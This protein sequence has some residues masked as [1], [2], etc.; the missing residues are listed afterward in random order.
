MS[1]GKATTC[2]EDANSTDC[3]LQL[4]LQTLEDQIATDNAKFD[5]DPL[6]F[7]FTVPIALI[8]ALFALVTIFQAILAAGPGRRKSRYRA[9][10]RWADQ[11][12]MEWSWPDMTWMSIATTPLLRHGDLSAFL[13]EGTRTL[14][15][16]MN[17]Q[18]TNR[19]RTDTKATGK[20]RR[21]GVGGATWLD[22]L[23]VV[24]LG[25]F[26][27]HEKGENVKHL[28]TTADYL[29]G[30]LL[31]VPAYLDV[32]LI[33]AL[34]ATAGAQ[35]IR[36][37]GTD[38]M[39]YPVILGDNFQFDFRQHPTLGIIGAFSYYGKDD[40]GLLS[41]TPNTNHLARTIKHA[42]GHSLRKQYF[43][44][45]VLLQI[46][47]L[48]YWFGNH[49]DLACYI[50]ALFNTTVALLDIEEMVSDCSGGNTQDRDNNNE[51]GRWHSFRAKLGDISISHIDTL[52]KVDTICSRYSEIIEDSVDSAALVKYYERDNRK[53]VA[54]PLGNVPAV[55]D[56]YGNV[57]R[58]MLGRLQTVS[59]RT[60]QIYTR[61]LG[62]HQDN[63]KVRGFDEQQRHEEGAARENVEDAIVWRVLLIA[64]L[65]WTA[66][67]SSEVL[68]SSIWDL[69]IP[70]I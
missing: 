39:P 11:T 21:E 58:Y 45:L 44:R 32:G 31:A 56:A 40:N 24:G 36:A 65:F 51:P 12:R 60:Y 63:P 30:D 3:L 25:D 67:D 64:M 54:I 6:T 57:L 2:L 4:L 8:A 66:P 48:D 19:G 43:R 27:L 37:I 23:E 5:W 22:L 38:S 7:A 34:T 61:I 20:S 59:D 41:P 28:P 47:H 9:I 68:K 17:P 53:G 50:T 46:Q 52:E 42:Q 33:V 29:P 16:T 35:S 49:P 55:K 14:G 18:M 1:I 10:G 70:V 15:N 26:Y 62:T 69:V 13:D